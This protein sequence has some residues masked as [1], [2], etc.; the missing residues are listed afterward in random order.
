LIAFDRI[1]IRVARVARAF[2][3]RCM[4]LRSLAFL[5]AL[6]TTFAACTP[7]SDHYGSCGAGCQSGYVCVEGVCRAS[8]NPACGAGLVCVV[9]SA[10]ATCVLGD[11]ATGDVADATRF[12]TGASDVADDLVSID[13]PVASDAPDAADDAMDGAATDANDDGAVDATAD[14]G[15]PCG[16]AGE[17]CCGNFCVSGLAC[18][19]TSTCVAITRDPNECSRASDCAASDV[20]GGPTTCGD[21][22]CFVCETSP[23]AAPFGA[24]CMAPS[25]CATGVCRGQRCTIPCDLG[26]TGDA[27]CAARDPNYVC[28]QLL[29]RTGTAPMTTIVA[30]GTCRQACARLAD[31]TVAGETCLPQLNYATNAMQFICG[32]TSGTV[33]AGG[34]CAS[35]S[36]CQSLLCVPGVGPGGAGACTAPCV[37][38]ADC[39]AAASHCAPISWTRP[40]G[41]GQSGHGCLP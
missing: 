5:A 34:A 19:G 13:G 16:H 36:E 2:D 21:H 28:T 15:P 33:A 9:T 27:D 24:P 39:P 11:A 40:D 29:Y 30:L 20:C 22:G 26:G 41:T 3:A 1:A 8:C 12:D 38:D 37:T 17:M 6:A 23:G 31:C 18:D 32:I 10:S 4:L 35:G 7:R 14:A 25:E